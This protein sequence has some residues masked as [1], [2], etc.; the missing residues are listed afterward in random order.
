MFNKLDLGQNQSMNSQGC[1]LGITLSNT[2][3][4]QLG[5]KKNAGIFVKSKF[6]EGSTFSFLLEDKSL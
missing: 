5:P 2:M 4:K 6:G 1:G 3:S